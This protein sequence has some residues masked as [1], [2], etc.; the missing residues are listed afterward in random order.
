MGTQALWMGGEASEEIWREPFSPHQPQPQGL[1]RSILPLVNFLSSWW[2]PGF[3]IIQPGNQ[4]ASLMSAPGCKIDYFYISCPLLTHNCNHVT[5][6]RNTKRSPVTAPQS[7][8]SQQDRVTHKK[9]R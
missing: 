8:I 2:Y 5:F 3:G 1:G 7:V 6:N 4:A 9:G